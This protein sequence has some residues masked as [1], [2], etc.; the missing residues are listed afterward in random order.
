M[1]T[2]FYG[3]ISSSGIIR[4]AIVD[5]RDP[6]VT[7]EVDPRQTDDIMERIIVEP[8]PLDAESLDSVTDYT[9]S[10]LNPGNGDSL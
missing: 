9:I 6:D 1:K 3:P 10:I 5:F 7:D 8:F 4:K 2:A